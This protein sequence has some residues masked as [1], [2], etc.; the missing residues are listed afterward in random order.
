MN[1]LRNK[2]NEVSCHVFLK[3]GVYAYLVNYIHVLYMLFYYMNVGV[4]KIMK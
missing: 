4:G 3:Q 2:Y 1:Y